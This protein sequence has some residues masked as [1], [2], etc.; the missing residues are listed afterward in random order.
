[1]QSAVSERQATFSRLAFSMHAWACE[2]RLLAW[3]DY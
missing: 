3:D 2:A 1:M